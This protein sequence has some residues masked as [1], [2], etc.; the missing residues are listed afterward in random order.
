MIEICEIFGPSIQGEGP[1]A[2][3]VCSFIRTSLCLAPFCSFCDS[4][5]SWER[6]EQM[7]V[8]DIVNA[9]KSHGTNLVVIT[10]GE[11]YLQKDLHKLIRVLLDNKYQVQIET[12]GKVDFDKVG[13]EYVVCSPKIYNNKLTFN[14]KVHSV[15][16]FKFVI[17]KENDIKKINEFAEKNNIHYNDIWL[18]PL[19]T[20]DDETDKQLKELTAKLCIENK[21]NY[22]PRLHID[23]W[24]QKRGV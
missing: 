18:M 19:T 9:I 5:Y 1:F 17:T 3:R 4:K 21:Y 6:G 11:P 23:I 22:S 12:S 8:Q 16:D 20:Y 7:E 10:G 15:Q 24:G 14:G 13:G 2:G